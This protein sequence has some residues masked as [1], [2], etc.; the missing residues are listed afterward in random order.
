VVIA[1]VLLVAVIVIG[2]G[3]LFAGVWLAFQWMRQFAPEREGELLAE[4]AALRSSHRLGREATETHRAM[5]RL[6]RDHDRSGGTA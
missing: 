6:F 2:V 5:Q 1:L 3:G 4:L